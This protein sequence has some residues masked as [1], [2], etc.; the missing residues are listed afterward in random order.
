MKG[1]L[2]GHLK[3]PRRLVGGTRKPCKL[4][5]NGKTP[6]A[7]ELLEGFDQEFPNTSEV[8]GNLVNAYYDLQDLYQ[9]EY[10]LRQLA[11]CMPRDADLAYGLAGV[12]LVNGR[13]S[14]AIRSF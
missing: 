11:R 14:V 3:P 10:A 6:E 1:K 8:G 7:L 9:Y 12:Y 4:L 2:S 13:Q 5:E